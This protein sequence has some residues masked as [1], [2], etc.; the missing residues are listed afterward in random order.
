MRL[1]TIFCPATPLPRMSARTVTGAESKLVWLTVTRGT[2]M[3]AGDRR[4]RPRPDKPAAARP[5]PRRRVG[6][7]AVG[8]EQDAGERQAAKAPR[9]GIQ[10]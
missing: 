5:K 9:Q 6:R 3:S 2:E 8:D 1:A 10:R 4:A 7:I